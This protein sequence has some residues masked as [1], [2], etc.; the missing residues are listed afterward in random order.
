MISFAGKWFAPDFPFMNRMLAVFLVTL[1]LA[2]IVSLVLPARTDQNRT[3]TADVDYRTST[4][5]N[6]AGLGVI[7]I[8]AA[9]YAT[10]W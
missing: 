4:G 6:I 9:L 10:W 5:F 7:L 1:A 3:V 2:V 8:L